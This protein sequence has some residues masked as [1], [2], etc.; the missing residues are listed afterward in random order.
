M[1]YREKLAW[2]SLVAMALTLIPYLAY[3]SVV[4]SASVPDA[5]RLV[6][7]A[8]AMGAM[9]LILVAGRLWLRSNDP[10]VARSPADGR[11]RDIERRA[12]GAAYYILIAGF[13]LVG[14]LMPFTESGW[15]VANAAIGAIVLAEVVR[16]GMAIWVY[17]Q[18][19]ARS[20]TA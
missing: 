9:A 3:T 5:E 17:R 2:L 13:V 16:N 1:P 18:G 6:L 7:L 12:I 15:T 4:R 14:G 8:V 20:T 11:D 19:L 10:Q